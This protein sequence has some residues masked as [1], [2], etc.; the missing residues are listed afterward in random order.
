MVHGLSCS[1]ACGIFPDQGSNSCPC[2]GRQILNHYA[3]REVCLLP[4][5]PLPLL[6]FFPPSPS[7]PPSL[8]PISF[9]LLPSRQPQSEAIHSLLGK[10]AMGKLLA[11]WVIYD[12][13][14]SPAACREECSITFDGVLG[15]THLSLISL[16]STR[17]AFI[18]C[19]I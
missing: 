11:L 2:I 14:L 15:N 8:S 7:L 1:S 16:I 19:F 18:H 9:L 6:S 3:A 17:K 12:H 5:S 4:P 13:L 10:R